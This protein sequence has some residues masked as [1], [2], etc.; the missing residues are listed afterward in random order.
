MGSGLAGQFVEFQRLVRHFEQLQ[1]LVFQSRLLEFGR[2]ELRRSGRLSFQQ[3][4]RILQ[5]AFRARLECDYP[6]SP[7]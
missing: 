4:R 3:Y 5:D 7:G 6:P 1:R 2:L